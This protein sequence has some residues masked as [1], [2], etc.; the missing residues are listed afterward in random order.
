MRAVDAGAQ[1]V[2]G[3]DPALQRLDLLQRSPA[4][5]LVVPEAG[6]GHP[7]LECAQRLA[8][9]VEVKD[10]SAA[11]RVAL[12]SPSMRDSRSLFRHFVRPLKDLLPGTEH[13]VQRS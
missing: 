3:L 13:F 5:L 8:L 11:P 6:V 1:L 9:A 4:L 2:V 12:C 7:R 10:T